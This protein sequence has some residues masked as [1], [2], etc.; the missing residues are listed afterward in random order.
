M[1]REIVADTTGNR[2]YGAK[3]DGVKNQARYLAESAESDLILG[4]D[5]AALVSF[6]PG[7]PY[8]VVIE[9]EVIIKSVRVWFN[10]MWSASAR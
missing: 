7:N 9:D 2:A 4:D 5:F 1:T 10:T 6:N 8:A 3:K